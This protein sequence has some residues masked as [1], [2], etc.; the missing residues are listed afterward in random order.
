MR[1]EP[2]AMQ[3]IHRIMEKLHDKRNHLSEKEILADIHHSAERL[4]K[5]GK[6]NLKKV[7]RKANI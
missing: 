6:L 3:E 7:E 4:I 1:N 2:K 5:E